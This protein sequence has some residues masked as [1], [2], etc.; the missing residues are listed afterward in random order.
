MSE[1]QGNK[2]KKLV[3]QGEVTV[4]HLAKELDRNRGSIYYLY[5]K[6]TFDADTIQK[7]KKAGV[8]I[9]KSNDVQ[10]NVETGQ[11]Q[12][13]PAS[14]AEC[15]KEILSL[16]E[17]ISYQDKLIDAQQKALSIAEHLISKGNKTLAHATHPKKN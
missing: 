10:T 9:N 8:D 3:R 4:A 13:I 17:K 11:H 12:Q 7:L 1:H 16:R 6:E 5:G 2:L 15:Q 14:L